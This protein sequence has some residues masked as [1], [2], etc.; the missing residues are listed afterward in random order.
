VKGAARSRSRD[1]PM[2]TVDDNVFAIV[3]MLLMSF[4]LIIEMAVVYVLLSVSR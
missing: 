1:D 4:T 3:V 2:M